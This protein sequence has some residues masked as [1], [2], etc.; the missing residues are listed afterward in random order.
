MR[1]TS[2]PLPSPLPAPQTCS[3]RDTFFL[4]TLAFFWHLTLSL[5]RTCCRFYLL[6]FQF[7]TSCIDLFLRNMRVYFL[8]PHCH[9]YG[10][11]NFPLFLVQSAV[12]GY[13]IMPIYVVYS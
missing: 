3:A 11:V 8:H 2:G 10:H 6:I 5:Q 1:K 13:L 7:F 12:I 4:P 9:M